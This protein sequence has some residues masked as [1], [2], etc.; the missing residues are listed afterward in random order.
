MSKIHTLTELSEKNE[1]GNGNIIDKA[2]QILQVVINEN[3][4]LRLENHGLN[5][6][7]QEMK[8]KLDQSRKTMINKN[9]QFEMF[10]KK[11]II[12]RLFI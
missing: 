9:N 6:V 7:A 4:N 12:L 11:K 5:Y 3:D 8:T 10:W 2:Q 1:N